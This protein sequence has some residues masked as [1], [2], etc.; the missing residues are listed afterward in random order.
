[1]RAI[2]TT[3]TLAVLVALGTGCEREEVGE[4]SVVADTGTVVEPVGV[5]EPIVGDGLVGGTAGAASMSSWDASRDGML[6]ENEFSRGFNEGNWFDD[7]DVDNDNELSESEFQ[8]VNAGWGDAPGGVD[9]NGLF[10]TWDA[11]EDGLVDNNEFT[12]GV[13]STW[14]A[15]RNNMIDTTEYNAGAN[16]FGWE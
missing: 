13:Y 8:T 1:M 2:A 14:D 7:W 6:D 3:L 12:R 4:E 9:E 11:D 15:D 16:W 10:D 5:Q